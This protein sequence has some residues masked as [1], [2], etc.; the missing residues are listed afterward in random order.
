MVRFIEGSRNKKKKK[1]EEKKRNPYKTGGKFRV[2][3][4]DET[5]NL[6]KKIVNLKNK[7]KRKK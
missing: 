7:K 4:I 1:F 5:N 6:S 3:N 2:M